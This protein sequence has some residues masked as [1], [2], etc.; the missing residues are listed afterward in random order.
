MGK[1]FEDS[2][3]R[4]EDIVNTLEK[5]EKPLD[6]TIKLFEEGLQLVKSCDTTLKGYETKVNSIL[7]KKEDD[8]NNESVDF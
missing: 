3:A 6:E 1:S 7:G 5:N 4:L 8:D 2:M